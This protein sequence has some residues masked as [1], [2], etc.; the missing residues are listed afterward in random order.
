M[1]HGYMHH[2]LAS[3]I[4]KNPGEV[5]FEGYWAHGSKEVRPP[6]SSRL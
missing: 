2:S 5:R 6:E 3:V 1:A 4:V